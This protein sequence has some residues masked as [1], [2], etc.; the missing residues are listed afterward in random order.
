ML[1]EK[2]VRGMEAWKL[3]VLIGGCAALIARVMSLW[4]GFPP[5]RDWSFRAKVAVWILFASATAL[6]SLFGYVIW[7]LRESPA[8]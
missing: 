4:S 5:P 1:G 6:V 7:R 8:A 3:L 2:R